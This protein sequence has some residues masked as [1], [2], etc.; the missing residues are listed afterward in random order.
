[1]LNYG[2]PL[3]VNAHGTMA[4]LDRAAVVM[5][6]DEVKV[7][8]LAAAIKRLI[9]EPAERT[10]LGRAGKA[11]DQHC[12]QHRKQRGRPRKGVRESSMKKPARIERMPRTDNW[13]GSKDAQDREAHN[14]LPTSRPCQ[15]R[16]PPVDSSQ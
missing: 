8:D 7:P 10:M 6:D 15:S 3:I 9:D 13:E 12:A 2:V 14:R 4:E 5:L 11:L 16:L 1:V